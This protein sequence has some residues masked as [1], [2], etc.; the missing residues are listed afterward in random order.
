VA[1]EAKKSVY[2]CRTR[3]IQHQR[4]KLD[5]GQKSIEHLGTI[6]HIP[7]L[8]KSADLPPGKYQQE[9]DTYDEQKCA[10]FLAPPRTKH[11][12]C[13]RLVFSEIY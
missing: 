10:P 13:R 12:R 3:A 11:G 4:L 6:W 9:L 5:A 2:L 1:D 7:A 8:R